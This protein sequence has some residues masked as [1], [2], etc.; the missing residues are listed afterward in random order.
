M[1]R[2]RNA[3]WVR[4]GSAAGRPASR[5]HFKHP[6]TENRRK[7]PRRVFRLGF[8]FFLLFAMKRSNPFALPQKVS[9][10]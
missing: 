5:P 6:N 10:H 2:S 4:R 3:V 8:T 9:G 7:K 1:Q